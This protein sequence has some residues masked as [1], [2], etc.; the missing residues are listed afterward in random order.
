M[1][2]TKNNTA[3][4]SLDSFNGWDNLS[5]DDDFFS[6]VEENTGKDDTSAASVLDEIN[7]DVDETETDK[8]DD[9]DKGKKPAKKDEDLF[10]MTNDDNPDVE[11]DEE[12]EEE[13]DDK[14]AKTT[15]INI[16]TLNHLKEKGLVDFELKEGEELTDELA[17]EILE[18]KYEES[19]ES[20]IKDLFEEL[21]EIV[22]NINKFAMKGGNVEQLFGSLA[23]NTPEGIDPEMDLESEANQELVVR[24]MMALDDE[25]DEEIEAQVS[26]LKD[27]GKLKV[28]AERKFEKW[29]ENRKKFIAD[30]AKKQEQAQIAQ[31]QKL[32]ENKREMSTFLTETEDIGGLAFSKEDKKALPSYMNDR[33]VKLQNGNSITAMQHDLFNEV[34]KNKEASIQLAALLRNR[35]EDGTF[36]FDSVKEAAQTELTQEVRDNVRRSRS[37]IPNGSGTKRTPKKRSIA[38]YFN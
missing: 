11:G 17:S 26:Y 16:S 9:K 4:D 19:I 36:N 31:K 33:S 13:D 2:T 25:T 8:G 30:E 15:S 21:P 24:S 37:S 7:K 12:E 6:D 38:D 5:T 29:K 1:E 27:S 22:R 35:N 10:A 14:G 18:D 28:I 3:A 20:G 34:F 32:R 23:Q